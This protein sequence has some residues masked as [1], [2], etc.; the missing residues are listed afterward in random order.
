MSIREPLE[1]DPRG[2]L[3]NSETGAVL[4][5]NEIQRYAVEHG[6]IEDFSDDCLEAANYNLRLGSEYRVSGKT[7]SLTEKDPY[8]TIRPYE[9]V[10]LST[11][12]RLQLPR[13]VIG[14][15]SLRVTMAYEGLLWTGG[16][17]VDPGYEGRLYCP[18]YNLSSRAIHLK[19]KDKI[20]SIDFVRTTPFVVDD[21]YECKRWEAKR[22]DRIDEYDRIGLNSQLVE[23]A[24]RAEDV[25]RRMR[26]FETL[27][28]VVLSVIIAAIA[29]VA[30]V[31]IFGRFEIAK[32]W[33]WASFGLSILGVLLGSLALLGVL[34]GWGSGKQKKRTPK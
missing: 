32:W 28:I 17:Q 2:I 8:V 26:D 9:V 12:E 31:G 21:K 18:V 3:R 13:F 1:Q 22:K 15:W 24:L 29:V 10:V 23:T 4:L 6:M 20:F 5:S 25:G 30:T 7:V 14:R 34:C 27:I 16:A 11:Y 33:G 19:W